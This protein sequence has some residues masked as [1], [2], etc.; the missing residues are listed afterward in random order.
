MPDSTR[1]RPSCSNPRKRID[2]AIEEPGTSIPANVDAGVFSPHAAGA[3]EYLAMERGTLRLT[4]DGAPHT[5]HPG[6]SIYYAGDCWHGFANPGRA[7]C[8]Y[9]LAME[10]GRHRDARRSRRAT[11]TGSPPPRQKRRR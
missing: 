10:L 9:Y 4:L 1:K 8:V 6:D 5:L 3:R 2:S 11:R 7:P